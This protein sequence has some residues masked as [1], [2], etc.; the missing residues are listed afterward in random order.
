MYSIGFNA[1]RDYFTRNNF[2]LR[3]FNLRDDWF[4]QWFHVRIN[5]K[6]FN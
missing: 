4:W 3:D 1:K 2:N 6:K 5:I